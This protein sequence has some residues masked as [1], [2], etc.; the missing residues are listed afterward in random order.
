MRDLGILGAPLR[1]AAL[2]R[3]EKPSGVRNSGAA[4]GERITGPVLT[5]PYGSPHGRGMATRDAQARRR[6]EQ[7]QAKPDG[8]LDALTW[9]DANKLLAEAL[10]LSRGE[11]HA[12][13]S[14]TCGRAAD[15]FKGMA[16]SSLQ[17][18]NGIYWSEIAFGN[19][20][21]AAGDR[22]LARARYGRAL[23]L[24]ETLA[25]LLSAGHFMS[26]DLQHQWKSTLQTKVTIDALIGSNFSVQSDIGES[27]S[28]GYTGGIMRDATH[29]LNALAANLGISFEEAAAKLTEA[30]KSANDPLRRA[31][32]VVREYERH[33]ELPETPEVVAARSLVNRA[34]YQSGPRRKA[35]TPVM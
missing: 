8:L 16:N 3:F 33:P 23:Y 13:A 27:K 29:D 1:V 31:R 28:P 7:P 35:K 24:I 34:N 5:R 15:F 19:I 11:H 18:W 30:A 4:S 22:E 32:R 20:A 26:D 2:G 25:D 10:A 6:K 14:R 17:K 21:L 12:E 9:E